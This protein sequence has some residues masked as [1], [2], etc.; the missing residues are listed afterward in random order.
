MEER[1]DKKF[2]KLFD[3][4]NELS[5]Q[6]QRDYK[7][8]K[9]TAIE[10]WNMLPAPEPIP[11]IIPTCTTQMI[12]NGYR[13]GYDYGGE[14]GQFLGNLMS[15]IVFQA[16]GG[17]YP[18]PMEFNIMH[19]KAEWFDKHLREGRDRRAKD[20]YHQLKQA[21]DDYQRKIKEQDD[22]ENA[23]ADKREADRRRK[24]RMEAY[25][26]YYE[27]NPDAWKEKPF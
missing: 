5:R 14:G 25:R 1:P 9:I 23:L 2:K 19:Q 24:V 4:Y 26:H 17:F 16:W 7:A 10:A 8:K 11:N 15:D 12:S 20:I 21:S 27:T 6:I 18:F 3:E 22:L 13:H